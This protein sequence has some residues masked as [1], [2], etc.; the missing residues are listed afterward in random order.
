MHDTAASVKDALHEIGADFAELVRTASALA[1]S[2]AEQN[3][4][5][6]PLINCLVRHAAARPHPLQDVSIA[7]T[8]GMQVRQYPHTCPLALSAHD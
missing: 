4:R 5:M 8:A 3:V 6:T 7:R 1:G 2:I